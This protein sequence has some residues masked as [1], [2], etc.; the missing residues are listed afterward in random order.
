MKIS[1]ERRGAICLAASILVGIVV[2]LLPYQRLRAAATPAKSKTAKEVFKNVQVLKD[3]PADDLIP[4][5]Q[6]ITASLGVECDFCHVRDAFEKDDKKTKQT[7]RRMMQMMFAIN[8]QNFNGQSKVSCYSCHRGSSTPVGI[9]AVGDNYAYIEV[10]DALSP[11]NVPSVNQILE[12]YISAIGGAAAIE[13]I[14]A[15]IQSG[16]IRFAAGPALPV[17]I[18]TKSPGKQI[19]AVHLPSGDAITAFSGSA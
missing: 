15:R 16:T 7:A 6:F 5:M 11:S 8:Q 18:T 17:K 9:P 4:S 3:I 14:T 12:K 19:M 10:P 1:T 13:K 2:G